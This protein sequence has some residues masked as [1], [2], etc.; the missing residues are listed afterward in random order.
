MA[1]TQHIA[2]RIQKRW[3]IAPLLAICRFAP[4]R[5]KTIVL[6]WLAKRCCAIDAIHLVLDGD[7]NP[8][9]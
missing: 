7:R 6:R 9:S 2:V 5:M 1:S 8:A 4:Q 3:F